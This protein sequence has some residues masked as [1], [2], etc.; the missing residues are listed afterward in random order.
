[1]AHKSRRELTRIEQ[2]AIETIRQLRADFNRPGHGRA[3]DAV[4]IMHDILRAYNGNVKL[5]LEPISRSLGRTMRTLEREFLARHS[6]TMNDFHER[7]RLE[8][9][10]RQIKHNPSV[11]LTAIAAELG[12]DRE[13]EFR[14]FFRRKRGEPPT[15][16]ARRMR[17]RQEDAQH[18]QK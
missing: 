16:F 8:Y 9:A 13:S 5:H 6:E 7:M 12:Y 14:R 11:K 3:E 4:E 17:D 10:E 2:E 15:A 18:P 1:M